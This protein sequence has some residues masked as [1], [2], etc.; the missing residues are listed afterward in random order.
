MDPRT[1]RALMRLVG[2]AIVVLGVFV[3]A[4]AVRRAD[5]VVAS[6]REVLLGGE[7]VDVFTARSLTV[8]GHAQLSGTAVALGDLDIASGSLRVDRAA[9]RVFA[10]GG[11]VQVAEDASVVFP[12][13]GALKYGTIRSGA[14]GDGDTVLRDPDAVAQYAAMV[15]SLEASVVCFSRAPSTGIVRMTDAGLSLVG[16]GASGLQVFHVD[17]SFEGPISISRVP[18]EASVLVNVTGT[19]VELAPQGS[20]W[21]TIAPN[22]LVNVP[23]A[24]RVDILAGNDLRLNTLVGSTDGLVSVS[25]T[26]LTGSLLSLSA[27]EVGDSRLAHGPLLAPLLPDCT[28]INSPVVK[29]VPTPVVA[30]PS[31]TD[32]SDSTVSTST[33][34]STTTTTVLAGTQQPGARPVPGAA[35]AL[36]G[37]ATATQW[38]LG[39][40]LSL[41]GAALLGWAW[42]DNHYREQRNRL[43]RRLALVRV[44]R[45]AAAAKRS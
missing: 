11:A 27:V 6:G 10:V 24:S 36:G 8:D 21:A 5:Q 38:W 43:R 19:N 42:L 13:T 15:S 22:T 9:A 41:F 28:P 20:D 1:R 34:S 32:E 29:E 14:V 25:G 40:P 44:E 23:D 7:M 26:R 31:A 33:T 30:P 3:T 16:D 35:F 18:R 45:R 2:A 39:V 17:G 4:T 37:A 12:E